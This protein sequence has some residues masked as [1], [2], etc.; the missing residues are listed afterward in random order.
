MAFFPGAKKHGIMHDKFNN[1]CFQTKDQLKYMKN[2]IVS[3]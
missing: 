3:N 1:F 2:L